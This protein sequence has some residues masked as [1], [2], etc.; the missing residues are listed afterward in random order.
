[1]HHT[2]LWKDFAILICTRNFPFSSAVNIIAYHL[3][4][5]PNSRTHNV[6]LFLW[7]GSILKLSSPKY[8]FLPTEPEFPQL[9]WSACNWGHWLTHVINQHSEQKTSGETPGTP[10]GSCQFSNSCITQSLE[11]L[12]NLFCFNIKLISDLKLH[13]FLLFVINNNI[14]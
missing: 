13:W 5:H 1:M 4:V 9:K 12:T 10:L 6:N 7:Q 2:E 11:I 14:N 8:Y 3:V